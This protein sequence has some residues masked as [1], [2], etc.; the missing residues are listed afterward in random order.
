MQPEA[1]RSRTILARRAAEYAPKRLMMKPRGN[2]TRAAVLCPLVFLP[3]KGPCVLFTVR[4]A[5]LRAHGG[6]ASFPGG[7]I[8]AGESP[9]QAALRETNEELGLNGRVLGLHDDGFAIRTHVTPCIGIIDDLVD[10]SQLRLSTDEV[11]SAFT[12]S[13]AHLADDANVSTEYLHPRD[14][15]SAMAKEGSVAVPSYHGGPVRVWGFTAFAL[16][17]MLRTVLLPSWE[18]SYK[19]VHTAMA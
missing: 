7:K 16:N 12:L 9:E 14:G 19:A 15:P 2:T 18:E 4:S 6:Q 5:D 17:R 3:G 13:L 8:D 1:I 10:M 11:A